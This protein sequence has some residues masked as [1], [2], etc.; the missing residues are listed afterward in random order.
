MFFFYYLTLIYNYTNCWL[1]ENK[2]N[3]IQFYYINNKVLQTTFFVT[4]N[5]IFFLTNT[6]CFG[7]T[8]FETFIFYKKSFCKKNIL[9]YFLFNEGLV[10]L[11]TSVV[12]GLK[13]LEKLLPILKLQERELNEFFNIN[14]FNK[15]DSRSL[16]LWTTVGGF[17][18]TKEFPVQGFWEISIDG[19]LNLNFVRSS[20]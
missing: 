2:K 19:N 4:I 7:L 5:S 3:N 10:L 17:P 11:M 13:T 9:T 12:K 1:Y 15:Y 8:A 16:F 18:L 6:F 20:V 14:F